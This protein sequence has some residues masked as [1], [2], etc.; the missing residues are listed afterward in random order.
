MPIEIYR[1][2]ESGE[3]QLQFIAAKPKAKPKPKTL[4]QQAEENIGPGALQSLVTAAG[5]GIQAGVQEFQRSGDLGKA[6][7]AGQKASVKPLEGKGPGRAIA[8]TLANAPINMVQEGSDTIRD[9]GAAMG[10]GQGTSPQQPNL[11]LLGTNV[12]LTKAKSSG[13]IEDFA[14]GVVQFGLEWITL[15]KALGVAG[16]AIKAAPGGTAAAKAVAPVTEKFKALEAAAGKA[17]AALPVAAAKAIAPNAPKVQAAAGAVGRRV[18]GPALASAVDASGP[19]G[20]LIDF[21]GFDQYEGRLFD[22][23][24]N[25]FPALEDVPLL[26]QLKTNPDD[27][28]LEG[29]VKNLVEGWGVGQLAGTLI[30]GIKGKFAID[31]LY[32]ATTPEQKA[33]ALEVVQQ[34]AA[35]FEK[36]VQKSGLLQPEAVQGPPAVVVNPETA[37]RIDEATKAFDQTR[38]QLEA[39]QA[40]EPERPLKGESKTDRSRAYARWQRQNKKLSAEF[41]ASQAAL[42]EAELERDFEALQGMP[43]APPPPATVADV[44]PLEGQFARQTEGGMQQAMDEAIFF[45]DRSA[46][47]QA[48][49]LGQQASDAWEQF[50]QNMA[51]DTRTQGEREAAARDSLLQEERQ[52]LAKYQAEGDELSARL[53]QQRIAKLEA[54]QN[55]NDVVLP[56]PGPSA[57]E[58]ADI[59]A[60][61]AKSMANLPPE[62]R[63]AIRD[64]M[65]ANKYGTGSPVEPPAAVVNEADLPG[66]SRFEPTPEEVQGTQEELLNLMGRYQRG[67]IPI[68]S[69]F[70]DVI[71]VK[72]PSGRMKYGPEIPE[73]Q[74]LFD[75]VSRRLDRII[76][77]GM[78]S[79]D[80]NRMAAEAMEDAHKWGLDPDEIEA[81]NVGMAEM[82]SNNVENAKNLIKLRMLVHKTGDVAG[83]KAANVLN[84]DFRGDLDYDQAAAELEVATIAAVRAMQMYRT[85]TRG[86]AQLL[87][88]TQAEIGDLSKVELVS[89]PRP[90]VQID[91]NQAMQVVEAETPV[92]TTAE[93]LGDK[94]SPAVREA[95]ETREWSPE[96]KS[97]FRSF[98][99]AVVDEQFSKGDGVATAEGVMKSEGTHALVGHTIAT[100][101][102][103]NILY[104]LGTLFT[105]VVNSV[106]KLTIEPAWAAT[107][108]VVSTTPDMMKVPMMFVRY[109]RQVVEAGAA[110]HLAK[111]SH[112]L[113]VTLYDFRG[114]SMEDAI[115]ATVRRAEDAAEEALPANQER[116]WNLN[117]WPLRK[118]IEEQPG[119]TAMDWAWRV[120]T[121]SLRTQGALD[122]YIKAVTG[123]STLYA[124]GFEE[125]LEK[126]GSEGMKQWSPE[127]LA[128]ADKWAKAKIKYFTDKAVINGETVADAVMK[129][130]TAIRI[131]RLLTFTDD[132]N[133]RMS[134]RTFTYGQELARAEGLKTDEEINAFARQYVSGQLP[135][136]MG[137]SKGAK[138]PAWPV[139]G[140]LPEPGEPTPWWTKSWSAIPMLWGNFQRAK[141]GYTATLIQPFNKS[142][143]D[144]TKAFVRMIPGANMTVDTLYRDLRDESTYVS[145]RWKAELATGTTVMLYGS[146]MLL[147][148]PDVEITGVGPYDPATRLKWEAS[149]RQPQS[150]RYKYTD[151]KGNRVWSAWISYRAFEP[152]ATLLSMMADY[153][154]M[155]ASL[156]EQER[157]DMGNAIVFK[158]AGDAMMRRFQATYYKGF[159]EFFEAIPYLG[160]NVNLAPQPGER[161]KLE[162]YLQK[163]VAD[164][165]VPGS[166][167][168]RAIRQAEDPVS[169]LIP[170]SNYF[171]EQI[172]EIK[173]RIPGWSKSLLPRRNWVSFEPLLNPGFLGDEYMPMDD[174]P[175]LERLTAATVISQTIGAIAPRRKQGTGYVMDEL[176]RLSGYGSTFAPPKP[177]EFGDVRLSAQ[178]Y[179]KYLEYIAAV[180]DADYVDAEG[181]QVKAK[182]PGLTQLQALERLMSSE[183]YQNFPPDAVR[184]KVQS[185]RT[186]AVS[187]VFTHFRQRGKAL[188][189]TDP[190][191]PYRVE[192]QGPLQEIDAQKK[193]N[194]ARLMGIQAPDA[195]R[196]KR[197]GQTGNGVS[198]FTQEMTR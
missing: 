65:L 180:P 155:H 111:K 93:L 104:N 149:G 165:A 108:Q 25:V 73:T 170:G 105:Q 188:F 41:E 36:E 187:Q 83:V 70:D 144:M 156:T 122:T 112:D 126:A 11:P 88:A 62:Q 19:K 1:D 142:P 66:T 184:E 30:K 193:V 15:S 52:Q 117:T 183:Q 181:R 38:A 72:S 77:L 42:R 21:A 113:G 60:T 67:E 140:R 124:I 55:P 154:E 63:V 158:L 78:P 133:A 177:T 54:G 90:Q 102:T 4:A 136:Q 64:Q 34:R 138:G 76:S 98:A 7:G 10:Y 53:T 106:A 75:A 191:N 46:D 123:N 179:D 68:N 130:P 89:R 178:A 168:L 174:A 166:G 22:L 95:M 13:G 167:M 17:G 43:D 152:V 171:Q 109:T 198:Q 8:R 103:A 145:K 153:K 186:A 61:L 58:I 44:V 182:Y 35:E 59:D 69:L 118:N 115:G 9:I 27:V 24:A 86:V 56:A 189:L 12:T 100:M 163:L 120:N 33:A 194:E 190:S 3:E 139:I 87:R 107:G 173:N 81:L 161:S 157:D 2:P 132:V 121:W 176:L 5:K 91:M 82:L 79:L 49:R 97:D 141:L 192:V 101:K 116:A 196:S 37:L 175:W 23:A 31:D 110:L 28:G 51:T 18:T 128:Y 162:K 84:A 96:A 172:D 47:V 16:K 151:A 85:I 134:D 114:G 159:L 32:A 143:G 80:L 147:N 127:A 92:G 129:H 74:V 40:A 146:H 119:P 71:A 45:G 135:S 29:R 14:T 197:G 48:A 131:G 99:A 125:G 6:V 150:I 57:A 50:K 26:N 169:R 137:L 20:M 39:H 195:P 94:I 185:T 148:N 160:A 164:I